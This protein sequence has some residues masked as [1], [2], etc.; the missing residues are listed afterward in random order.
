MNR[1]RNLFCVVTLIVGVT[2]CSNLPTDATNVV[3]RPTVVTGGPDI[4]MSHECSNTIVIKNGVPSST[5]STLFRWKARSDGPN[6]PVIA[7]DTIRVPNPAESGAGYVRFDMPD[8]AGFVALHK[9]SPASDTLDFYAYTYRSEGAV[10]CGQRIPFYS[11]VSDD[12]WS[13]SIQSDSVVI[14]QTVQWWVHG[15]WSTDAI[16]SVAVYV[17][18]IRQPG[19]GIYVSG[20]AVVDSSM[21]VFVWSAAAFYPPEPLLSESQAF[22][23][24]L[25][26][27]AGSSDPVAAAE[28]LMTDMLDF[29]LDANPAM[30]DSV[31]SQVGRLAFDF[32]SDSALMGQIDSVLA[33][34]MLEVNPSPSSSMRSLRSTP[35]LGEPTKIVLVNGIWT[36]AAKFSTSVMTTSAVLRD[37][38]VPEVV[39][40]KSFWNPSNPLSTG[41]YD[42]C[43]FYLMAGGSE[44]I[45]LSAV[46]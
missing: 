27:I 22:I 12:A 30:A 29:A 15:N 1:R 3:R 37:V 6:S 24:Q 17:N 20:S 39:R 25:R 14:G 40:V 35:Q 7:T 4:W 33:G 26:A 42:E 43:M 31:L 11:V 9:L 28:S 45:S 18:G 10:A 36:P 32:D 23:T 34:R 8:S 2:G 16:D 13:S 38:E 41:N 44:K 5:D 46:I 21:D 19:T